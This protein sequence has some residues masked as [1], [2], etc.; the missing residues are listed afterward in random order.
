LAKIPNRI[1][2]IIQ[3]F[4]QEA[5]SDNVNIE[6]AILFGSYAKG[7]QNKYSDIDLA[8]ISDDFEGNR[9]KDKSR[10]AKAKLRTSI[11]LEIHPFKTQD[12]TID[13]LFVKEILKE[14]IRLY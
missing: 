11:D 13:N 3:K 2:E 10:L 7:K 4:I 1:V 14:G 5:K 6:Q 8:V 12:F 9:F